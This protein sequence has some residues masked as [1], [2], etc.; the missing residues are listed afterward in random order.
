[1]EYLDLDSFFAVRKVIIIFSKIKKKKFT[2]IFENKF[3]YLFLADGPI[4]E[5]TPCPTCPAV[6]YLE[7]V[8]KNG[9]A[10]NANLRPGDFIVEVNFTNNLLSLFFT[11]INILNK[12]VSKSFLSALLSYQKYRR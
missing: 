5:F 1:M 7:S 3:K 8:E 10:W 9:P 11:P 4:S 2:N 6:Q 12:I